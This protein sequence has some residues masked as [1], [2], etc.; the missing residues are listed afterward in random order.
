MTR[1]LVP[2]VGLVAAAVLAGCGGGGHD[3]KG[4]AKKRP[5][6]N[7][8]AVRVIKGWTD[9]LRHGDVVAASRYFAVPVLVQNSG[10][11][12]RLHS[13]AEVEFFNRTLPCGAFLVR[14]QR[15]GVYTIGVF[16][17]TERPG[18]ACGSGVGGVAAVAFIVHANHITQWRRLA[19]VPRSDGPEPDAPA[20]VDPSAREV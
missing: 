18:G 12:L 14:S 11:A 9:T 4:S 19:D 7:P 10:D 15:R 8:A 20:P 6:P 1:A 3:S 13:R 2:V 5:A 16:R 17:L